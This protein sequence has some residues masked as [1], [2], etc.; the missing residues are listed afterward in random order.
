MQKTHSLEIAPIK[1]L[2]PEGKDA[3]TQGAPTEPSK[4]VCLRHRAK[5]K[6]ADIKGAVTSPGKEGCAKDTGQRPK[7]VSTMGVS[8]EPSKERC[9]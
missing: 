7:D 4:K 5:L 3:A 6:N 1:G 9:A 2:Q 8:T